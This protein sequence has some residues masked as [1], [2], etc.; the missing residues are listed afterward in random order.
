MTHRWRGSTEPE[1][2]RKPYRP[3]QA[4]SATDT[5]HPQDNSAS[6]HQG[7][8]LMAWVALVRFSGL[9]CWLQ[10]KCSCPHLMVP[11][12][13]CTSFLCPGIQTACCPPGHTKGYHWRSMHKIKLENRGKKVSSFLDSSLT[14]SSVP[15]VFTIRIWLCPSVSRLG[16][17]SWCHCNT[18][19][20]SNRPQFEW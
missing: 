1:G 20:Y 4:P 2:S 15:H 17:L 9:P 7:A 11:P 19:L 3:P 13:Q 5:A 12:W 18:L 10:S 8:A 6:Y 14:E 16:V